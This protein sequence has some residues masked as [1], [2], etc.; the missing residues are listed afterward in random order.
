MLAPRGLLPRP[1]QVLAEDIRCAAC[2]APAGN[3]GTD[4][5]VVL[6]V[7]DWLGAHFNGASPAP[8]RTC[9]WPDSTQPDA[10]G[11]RLAD[12]FG[13]VAVTER[14]HDDV[15][16][17]LEYPPF[18]AAD[19]SAECG[20][21]EARYGCSERGPA[22]VPPGAGFSQIGQKPASGTP[23]QP[24]RPD[25]KCAETAALQI[26]RSAPLKEL[27]DAVPRPTP[28]GGADS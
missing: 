26:R 16:H 4:A 1:A 22:H 20:G 28:I 10:Q 3:P 15:M 27:R 25:G 11:E 6:K 5:I 23:M 12:D 19:W 2:G 14:S 21:D 8:T 13:S 18:G 9:V 7:A 24:E 17:R